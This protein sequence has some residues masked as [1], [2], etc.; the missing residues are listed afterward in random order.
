MC[1]LPHGSETELLTYRLTRNPMQML[2]GL[3]AVPELFAEAAHLQLL[4]GHF[5]VTL[6]IVAVWDELALGSSFFFL[7]YIETCHHFF[8]FYWR[9]LSIVT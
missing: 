6:G 9:F 4:H 8:I 7:S 3:A 5:S 2:M 1:N